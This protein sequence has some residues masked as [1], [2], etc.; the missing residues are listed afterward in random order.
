MGNF[1]KWVGHPDKV[2][3]WELL[4]EYRAKYGFSRPSAVAEVRTGLWAGATEEKEF[5]ALIPATP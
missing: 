1:F 3:A 5:E 2:K 4:S